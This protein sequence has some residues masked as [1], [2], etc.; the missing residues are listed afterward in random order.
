M[1]VNGCGRWLCVP[2]YS[3][4]LRVWRA[5]ALRRVLPEAKECPFGPAV[6]PHTSLPRPG[7]EAGTSTQHWPAD[8]TPRPAWARLDR[9]VPPGQGQ[10]D[11]GTTWLPA[12]SQGQSPTHRRNKAVIIFCYTVIDHIRELCN[13]CCAMQFCSFYLYGQDRR[14]SGSTL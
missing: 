3:S 14:C 5:A 6:S 12:A 2:P 7:G 1:C 4:S 10:K 13:I 9:S 8:R 11:R